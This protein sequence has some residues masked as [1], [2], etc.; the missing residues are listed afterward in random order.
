[1]SPCVDEFPINHLHSTVPLRP[2]AR[3]GPGT[4]QEDD[5]IVQ[6][7][8]PDRKVHLEGRVGDMGINH[9]I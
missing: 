3:V 2:G 9:Q 4:Y 5:G 7:S 6:R 8:R 1:M